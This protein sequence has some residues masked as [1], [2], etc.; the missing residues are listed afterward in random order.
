MQNTVFCPVDYIVY[1]VEF[2]IK[3]EIQSLLEISNLITGTKD[4]SP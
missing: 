3:G 2:K 1:I 4:W